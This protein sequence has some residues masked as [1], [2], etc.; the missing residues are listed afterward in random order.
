MLTCALAISLFGLIWARELVRS[1]QEPKAGDWR[2]R[3]LDATKA[4]DHEEDAVNERE[5]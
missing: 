4:G 3:F 5:E 1:L 2:G